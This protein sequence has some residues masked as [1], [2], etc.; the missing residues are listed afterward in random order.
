[1]F[2]SYTYDPMDPV[3]SSVDFNFYSPKA[4]ETPLD[5]RSIES[6]FDVLVYTS[7]PLKEPLEIAGKPRMVLYAS[8]DCLDTD[9]ICLLSDVHPNGKSI[10]FNYGGI[11]ARFR[12]SF[13][14]EVFLKPNE[15]YRFEFDFFFDTNIL[16][17]VGHRIRLSITSSYFPRFDRN[18][19]S[20]E[21]IGEM[22][23]VNIA[24]NNVF[25]GGRFPS[26]IMLPIVKNK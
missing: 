18:F 21:P 7:E 14:K 6:R 10:L 5:S 22:S 16:I 2:D 11:R 1:S 12:E 3:I 20:N 13:E 9:W 19:N 17:D 23:K 15:I 26:S 4:I 8:S 25:H 24:H